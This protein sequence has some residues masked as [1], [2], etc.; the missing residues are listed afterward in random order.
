MKQLFLD[1]PLQFNVTA[2]LCRNNI[3]EIDERL[4]P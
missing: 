1:I 2:S 3:C 4:R